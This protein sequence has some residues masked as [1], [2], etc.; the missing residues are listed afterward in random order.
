MDIF[1]KRNNIECERR[2][3]ECTYD[4][5]SFNGWLGTVFT[6]IILL[7]NDKKIMMKFFG[8]GRAEGR[9]YAD[10]PLLLSA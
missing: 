8:I 3:R 5:S 10:N 7:I 1:F 9:V 4:S 2:E 6:C